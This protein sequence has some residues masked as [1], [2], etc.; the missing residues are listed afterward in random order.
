MSSVPWSRST[1]AL[2][3][4]RRECLGDERRLRAVLNVVDNRGEDDCPAHQA[5]YPRVEESE[6]Q[7]NPVAGVPE[8]RGTD[9]PHREAH[10]I[11]CALRCG[12]L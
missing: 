10:E 11:W 8:D 2:H 9:R 12:G 7:A 3:K 1:H 6:I 5:G 4:P